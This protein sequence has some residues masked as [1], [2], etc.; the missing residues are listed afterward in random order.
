MR[1]PAGHST[2]LAIERPERAQPI[3]EILY[4]ETLGHILRYLADSDSG[5]QGQG[6]TQ[7]LLQAA[8]HLGER[9]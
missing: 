1:L 6:L 5:F 7:I 4:E 8:F 2:N 3:P 9:S